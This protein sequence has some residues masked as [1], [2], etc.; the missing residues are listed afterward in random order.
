MNSKSYKSSPFRKALRRCYDSLMV[1]S[2]WLSMVWLLM[3]SIVLPHNGENTFQHIKTPMVKVAGVIALAIWG[4]FVVEFIVLVL[5]SRGKRN[6]VRRFRRGLTVLIFPA[7][8]VAQRSFY[9]PKEIWIPFIGWK[10]KNKK[11]FRQ[12]THAFSLPMICVVLLVLPAMAIELFKPTWIEDLPWVR[13]SL[14]IGQQFIWLAF[15]YEFV[16]MI[17]ASPK[18]LAYCMKHWIDLIIVLLPILLFVLPFLNL[19]PLVRLAR[20]G[21]LASL[22]QMLRMKRLGI[23]VFQLLALFAS[24]KQIGKNYHKRRIEKLYNLIDDREDELVDL[25]GELAKLQ[26]ELAE[27]EAVEEEIAGY[28][29]RVI[30]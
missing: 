17:A 25:R 24:T 30:E 20:L 7:F 26:Q 29:K 2:I 1:P 13:N 11:L 19:L 14:G 9:R 10:K 16:V 27:T 22:T 5:A 8:R 4:W 6:F 12:L 18:R 23:K 15:A 21:R 3:F 28:A